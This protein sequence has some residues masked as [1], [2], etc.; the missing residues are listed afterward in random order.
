ML[1]EA[2]GQ[3]ITT[4]A[5]NDVIGKTITSLKITEK[6]LL[7]TFENGTRMRLFDEQCCCEKR[8]MHTD[9]DLP[10]YVGAVFHGAVKRPGPKEELAYSYEKE[11]QF[12]IISTSKGQFTVVNYNEHNGSYGGF[13][14]RAAVLYGWA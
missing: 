7:L 1:N 13:F 6:E 4:E 8:F 5:F 3:D 11:S 14:L 2:T 10:Y 12:L 9:D